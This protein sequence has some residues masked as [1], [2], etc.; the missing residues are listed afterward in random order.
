MPSVTQLP[1]KRTSAAETPEGL[2]HPI[3]SL[4]RE[5]DRIF[6]D[7]AGAWSQWPLGRR[8]FDQRLFEPRMNEPGGW[9]DDSGAV[10]VPAVDIEESEKEYRISAE[11]P[12][13]DEKDIEVT[14]SD[15]TLTL[16]GEKKHAREERGQGYELCERSWGAFE[17]SFA[18]PSGVD[19]ARISAQFTRGVLELTLPKTAEAQKKQPRRIDVKA[20]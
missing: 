6:D 8:L 16:R 14:A 5:I 11:M 12:G 20:A 10:N 4:R 18:L 7:F 9:R 13:I 19:T 2:R 3:G 17:R 1:V 15:D